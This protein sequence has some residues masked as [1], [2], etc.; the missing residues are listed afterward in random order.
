MNR[1]GKPPDTYISKFFRTVC[2][3][4]WSRNAS[5]TASFPVVL[6][7]FGCDVTRQA[8]RESSP[9]YRT[10]FQASSRHSDSAK[11]PGYEAASRNCFCDRYWSRAGQLLAN[12]PPVSIVTAPEV[13]AFLLVSKVLNGF[14]EKPY[15]NYCSFCQG[16]ALQAIELF[17]K[18]S[19][20]PLLQDCLLLWPS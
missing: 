12:F 20:S 9:S 19:L 8:C 14:L 4:N 5:R 10:R 1:C 17:E 7:D 3:W 2:H 6:G 16:L 18:R 11:W 13:F 15:F